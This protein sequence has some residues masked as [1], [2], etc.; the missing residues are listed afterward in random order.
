MKITLGALPDPGGLPGT[1]SAVQHAADAG[2]SRIWLPQLPPTA[3]FPALDVLTTLALAGARTPGIELGTA[4]TVA[5]TQHPFVLAR[6]A[7]TASAASVGRLILGIGVSHEAVISDMFGLSYEAPAAYL[8]E[9][10]E[11][12][13]PALAGEPVDHHGK[14]I[15][16]VGQLVLPGAE[17]PP[18][19]ISAL[20][21]RML[22]LAGEL[23][24]GTVTTWAGLK[25]VEG[26]IVPRITRAAADAG[27]PAPQVVVG[28]PVSVTDDADAA[29]EQIAA[30]FNPTDFPAYRAI[31]DVEGVDSVGDICVFGNETEVAEQLGRFADAG[32]TEFSAIPM[33]D[34]ATI[35]RT[36]DVLAGL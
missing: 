10:L 16:A 12:L 2:F 31:F 35:T 25:A 33:G 17:A 1:L 29:R 3:Q 28:L 5:Q 34:P 30:S 27:R 20:G 4:V 23:T 26:H 14:R 19:V 24:E 32:A 13:I 15:T 18:V 11:V 7:L 22:Q 36:L 6:Q 21:P 9:Y 8:R